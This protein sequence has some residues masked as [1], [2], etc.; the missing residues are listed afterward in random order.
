MDRRELGPARDL[1]VFIKR[2]VMP[3]TAGKSQQPGMATLTRD[4]RRKRREAFGRARSAINPTASGRSSSIVAAWIEAGE[5]TRKADKLARAIRDQPIA[6]AASAEMQRRRKKIMKLGTKLVEI[7]PARRHRMRIQAKK[8]RYASDFFG[9]LFPARRPR[10]GEKNSSPSRAAAGHTWRLERY[11]CA[12]GANRAT[13]RRNRERQQ[14]K[15]PRCKQ[16]LRGRPAVA[17][18]R[19]EHR[20]GSQGSERAYARFAKAKPFWR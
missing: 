12:P 9:V 3:A 16:G 6:T 11:F 15:N 20:R 13:R 5:W 8:L 10:G 4:L 18:R 1:D 19:S 7:D 17:P 2:V 14:A